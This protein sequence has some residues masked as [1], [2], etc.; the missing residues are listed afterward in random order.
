MKIHL[1]FGK[2]TR[3]GNVLWGAFAIAMVIVFV[4]LM[5]KNPRPDHIEDT[6]GPQN[7]TL[8]SI[9]EQD[10]LDCKMGSRGAVSQEERKLTVGGIGISS[11]R[12]YSSKKFTG[13]QILHTTN[14]AKGSDLFVSLAEFE[15]KEGNFVFYI[16]YDGEIVGQINPGEDVTADFL[17]ND[18]EKSATL[19]YVI[20]GESASFR[21]IPVSEF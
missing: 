7:Y 13:V 17:L 21:F 6:N 19:E 1:N 15:V 10:V 3:G 18:V 2:G 4:V 20:A 5:I 14:L 12:E 9:T 11:G 8:Q 16:V